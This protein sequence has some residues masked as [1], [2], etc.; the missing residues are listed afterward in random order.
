[1]QC[2][3]LASDF[4]GTLARDGVV[5]PA[6]LAALERF[7]R[8]GRKLILV[9]GR[10]LEELKSVFPQLDLFDRVVAENGAVLYSPGT[11]EKRILAEPAPP[12][13]FEALRR[14]GVKPPE[15]GDV[16]LSTRR[17]AEAEVIKIIGELG[18]QLQVIFNKSSVMILP[19]GVNKKT[20]L[21][22]ALAELRLSEHNTVGIGDAEN[23]HVFLRFCQVAAAVANA[24]P[25]LKES[26]DVVT[27]G[28]Y[29]AGVSELIDRILAGEALGREAEPAKSGPPDAAA[30]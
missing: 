28:E 7:R 4:D 13:F 1:V 30:G 20:G 24:I 6:T 9:T 29:G 3:A 14:R 19:S 12:V 25:A 8:S 26:A 16:I 27:R 2:L 18:L 22:A 23:D 11:R 5:D 17:P 10:V 15:A 21:A